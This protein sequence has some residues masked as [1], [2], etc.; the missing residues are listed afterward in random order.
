MQVER[1]QN[2]LQKLL[3]DNPNSLS[4]EGATLQAIALILREIPHLPTPRD[5]YADV[6]RFHLKFGLEYYGPPRFLPPDMHGH[7]LSA[8]REEVDE[9]EEAVNAGDLIAAHDALID[10][11]YFA[12]GRAILHGF[13][14]REGWDAVHAANMRKQRALPD[15]SDSKRGYGCDVIKPPGWT[16]PDHSPLFPT[17]L[18]PTIEEVLKREAQATN[19]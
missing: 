3:K 8:L 17:K 5:V 10:L 6:Y 11:I 18:D 7:A 13:P 19:S 12:V 9:Y 4:M 16:A 2:R 15:G 14:F 1:I